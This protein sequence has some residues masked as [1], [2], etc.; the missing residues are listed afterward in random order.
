M[1]IHERVES[2][3]ERT[4]LS[5]ANFIIDLPNRLSPGTEMVMFNPKG[6]VQNPGVAGRSLAGWNAWSVGCK[7]STGTDELGK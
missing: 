7:L 5:C 3:E 2:E 6:R 1:L 4:V